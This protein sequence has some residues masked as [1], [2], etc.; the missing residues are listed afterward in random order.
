MSTIGRIF[1]VLNLL[2]AGGLITFN[3]AYLTN[4]TQYRTQLE[5]ER[6]ERTAQVKTLTDQVTKANGQVA[7]TNSKLTAAERNRDNFQGRLESADRENQRL[8]SLLND[9]QRNV[10]EITATNGKINEKI[11]GL[12]DE[13]QATREQARGAVADK[14]QAVRERDQATADLA[15]ANL[16][17]SNL[18]GDIAKLQTQNA[19]TLKDLQQEQLLNRALKQSLLANN[20]EVPTT[21]TPMITATVLRVEN[22]GNLLT[23]RKSGGEDGAEVEVGYTFSIY[24]GNSLNAIA[25]VTEVYSDGITA[26]CTYQVAPGTSG[27]SVGDSARTK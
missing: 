8:Q 2:L 20:I 26:F 3:G 21:L 17:I 23:L 18:N 19:N 25:T 9:V 15:D 22:R 14:D 6:E 13:L 7:S 27:P 16:N 1:V 5:T 12:N 4:A 24:S 11:D 10:T